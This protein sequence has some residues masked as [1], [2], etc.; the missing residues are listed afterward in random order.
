MCGR[1]TIKTP[2]HDLVDAFG[3]TEVEDQVADVAPERY[4]VAPTQPVP[5]VRVVG[6]GEGPAARHRKLALVRWG[7]VPFWA[8][9]A[10]IGA[11][12]IN[13]RAESV[14]TTPAFRAAFPRRRCLVLADGFYEWK[15]EGKTRFGYWIRRRDGRPFAM[16][17]LWERWKGEQKELDPPLETCTIITTDANEVVAPVHDRM[18]VI[19]DADDYARWLDPDEHGTETLT[20][21][22]HPCPPDLLE[23]IPVGTFVNDVRHDGPACIERVVEGPAAPDDAQRL[24]FPGLS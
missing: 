15:R 3:V 20:S 7:L 1:F 22:L 11:R 23:T 6:S 4:N 14:A 19:L 13:A 8:R 24:L 10:K 17:G 5:V 9:D 18:P 2:L 16:A 12:T 21:M